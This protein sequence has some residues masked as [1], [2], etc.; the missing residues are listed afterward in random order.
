MIVALTVFSVTC[1]GSSDDGGETPSAITADAGERATID[2]PDAET[3]A[4]VH[5]VYALPS[6]GEDRA[7]DTDGTIATSFEASERWLASETE[8]RRLRLDTYEGAPEVSFIRLSR[9]DADLQSEDAFT[10]DAIEAEMR[11]AGF[12]SEEKV[13]VVYYDGGS[14]YAC[15]SGAYPPD[16][17]GNVAVLFLHGLPLDGAIQCGDSEFAADVDSAG[18]W[19][20]V[21]VHEVL[22]T[23]GFVPKCAPNEALS[24]HISGPANDLM[25][26][27]EEE[28]E[29]AKALD[30]GHDDYFAAEVPGCLDFADSPYLTP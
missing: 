6:D 29:L 26:E 17:P 30:A 27:G 19:E 16:L 18:F 22:H 14:T 2:R 4:Q 11:A 12:D 23:L 20:Y 25:Y 21:A 5:L 15:G 13:Y 28:S 9:T 24:G 3:G 1:G 8:G 10:R 7:L